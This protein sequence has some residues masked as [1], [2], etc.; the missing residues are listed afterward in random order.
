MLK[1]KLN[2]QKRRELEDF[3]R[4]A[5]S[6]DSEKALIILLCNDGKS[7]QEI[8]GMLERNP[9]TV[10]LWVKRYTKNGIVGLSRKYS[11]GRPRDKK[12]SVKLHV[13]ERLVGSPLNY[14]Y[15]DAVW[16]V[17]LLAHDLKKSKNI[18]VSE[19]TVTRSLKEMGYV[20]KRP[21]KLPAGS[22]RIT[23][24]EKILAINQMCEKI[25]ELTLREQCVIYALD[26]SH[27]STEPYLVRGWFFKRW[28]SP[29]RDT[30]KERKSHILWML[31]SSDIK[32]LLEEIK[33]L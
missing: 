33:P 22:D 24:E 7:V 25:K 17:P 18:L 31:E 2:E 30:P 26:E 4:Q 11:P 12:D 19:D 21:S 23:P 15:Q 6:K 28:P 14:G 13:K 3:R 27:F 10:R 20:Y 5:S 9:H 1:V 29:D 8:A 32:I 16:T